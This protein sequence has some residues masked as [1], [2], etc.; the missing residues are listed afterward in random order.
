MPGR[1][2]ALPVKSHHFGDD[3]DLPFDHPAV[4]ALR[5]SAHLLAGDLDPSFD[6]SLRA[7]HQWLGDRESRFGAAF[8]HDMRIRS[9]KVSM[10]MASSQT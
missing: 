8:A 1:L 6:V 9:A 4:G 10:S 7:R 2:L 5:Q 3:L